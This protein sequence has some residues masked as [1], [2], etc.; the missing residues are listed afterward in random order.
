M[1]DLIEEMRLR[2]SPVIDAGIVWYFIRSC[3]KESGHPVPLLLVFIG[4]AI[5]SDRRLIAHLGAK[6]T[7]SSFVREV[8]KKKEINRL[9]ALPQSISASMKRTT[10][11]LD[12]LVGAGLVKWHFKIAALS[13]TEAAE[14]PD[15]GK[16]K[17][18]MKESCKQA[19]RLGF[20]F[21]KFG[22]VASVAD[23]LGVYL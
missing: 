1:L 9:A 6:K 13:S 7:L 22:D 4:H 8:V 12:V 21:A 15:C 17:G 2:E 20:V 10:A 18:S 14:M 5:L 16:L 23:E 19:E 11:A 3:E